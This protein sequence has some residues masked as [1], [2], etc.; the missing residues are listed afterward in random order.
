MNPNDNQNQPLPVNYLDQISANAPQKNKPFLGRPILIFLVVALLLI[1]FLTFIGS[2]GKN[3]DSLVK[4]QARLTKT[5]EITKVAKKYL[6]SNELNAIN[7]EVEI[8]ITNTLRDIGPILTK[9]NIKSGS[10]D[11]NVLAAESVNKA[12]DRLEDARLNAVFDRAY[13]T[14]M[15]YQTKNILTLINKLHKSSKSNDTKSFLKSAYQN[16]E[17]IQNKL[18]DYKK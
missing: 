13:T 5:T 4:L 1:T 17:Q 15:S 10:I 14:E 6:K 2:I 18:T 16:L 3:D 9:N 12:L 7:S 11:K 8:Y